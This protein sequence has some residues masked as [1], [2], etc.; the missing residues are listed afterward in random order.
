MICKWICILCI[1]SCRHQMRHPP[2]PHHRTP[3]PWPL[4]QAAVRGT[5]GPQL[6][7]W[8]QQSQP[9]R[10]K[11][12]DSRSRIVARP[13]LL[14]SVT[15]RSW[16][17]LWTGAGDATWPGSRSWHLRPKAELMDS[18]DKSQPWR[19]RSNDT[20]ARG[21]AICGR[22]RKRPLGRN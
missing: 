3:S 1:T 4:G 21:P 20:Q 13:A 16:T 22:L 14:T 10:M 7:C 2:C 8:T 19:M 17:R 18:A 6:S 5:C 11:S 12:D 15:A 9:W